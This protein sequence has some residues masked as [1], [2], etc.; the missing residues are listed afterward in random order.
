MAPKN[1][2]LLGIAGLFFGVLFLG[3]GTGIAQTTNI[4]IYD[5][6]GN[7][8]TGTVTDGRVYFFDSQGNAAFGTIRDG[9][10]FLNMT[11]GDITF[12]TVKRWQRISHG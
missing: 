1:T 7:Q 6:N 3:Q 4:F 5:S 10:V 11:K 8:A 12:G 9:N 2:I